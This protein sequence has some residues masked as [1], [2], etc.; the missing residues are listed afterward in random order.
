LSDSLGSLVDKL[1]TTSTKL[2]HVQDVVHHAASMGEGL[3]AD[4]VQ[5][6]AILN[7]ERNR[8]MTEI[9]ETLDEAVKAGGAQVDARIKLVH[10]SS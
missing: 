1:I 5:K 8:L 6:L 9:D 2:W 7:L 3:D 4:T 10:D